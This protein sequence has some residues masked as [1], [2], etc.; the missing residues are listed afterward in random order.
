[1]RQTKSSQGP[2]FR[3]VRNARFR[4]TIETNSQTPC[5]FYDLQEDP[6]E[7]NNLLA[8]SAAETKK[9]SELMADMMQ[10][11]ELRTANASG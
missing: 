8:G 3:A 11:V 2:T 6:S 1:M 7:T 5:E 9:F 4:M 10:A